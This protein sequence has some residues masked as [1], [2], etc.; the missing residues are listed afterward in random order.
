MTA[1]QP[2]F[3]EAGPSP[4]H[5]S[6]GSLARCAACG[7]ALT[8]QRRKWCSEA[9]R[10]RSA[11]KVEHPGETDG[12][13]VFGSREPAHRLIQP[14]ESSAGVEAIELAR[15]CGLELDPWQ[16]D[17]LMA[18]MGRDAAG[19]WVADEAALIVPRQN[20]KSEVLLARLLWGLLLG[21]EKTGLFTAH[22]HKTAT[23]SFLRLK[24]LVEHPDFVA[25]YGEVSRLQ[26]S[27]GR[28][29]I[30][31]GNGARALFIARSRK[32]GRGFSPDFIV[33]DEAFELND[34]SMAALKPGLAARK[35]PQLWFS[36]S[37]PHDTS[38]VLRRICLKGRAGEQERLVYF[39]WAAPDEVASGRFGGV[40][41]FESCDRL[42]DP[43][44]HGCFRVDQRRH[45]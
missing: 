22:E 35:S 12:S 40:A 17:F 13:V 28:E 21:G 41:G 2:V 23:E 15:L 29:Q 31:F 26:S 27:Y 37:A 36:S 20:G 43:S 4:G 34:L 32:N 5:P 18:A 8:G 11:R 30:E 19:R 7:N 42:S 1:S 24:S 44:R 3:L 6:P 25:K 14:S 9:C 33:L 45:G 38:S 39:E 10:M 16:A